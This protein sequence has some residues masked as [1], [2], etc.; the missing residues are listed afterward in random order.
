MLDVED[1]SNGKPTNEESTAAPATMPPGLLHERTRTAEVGAVHW[2]LQAY[3]DAVKS[4]D[5]EGQTALHLAASLG[6]IDICKLLVANGAD[7]NA[8]DNRNMTPFLV[9]ARGGL[10]DTCIVCT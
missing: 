6:Y 5:A 4:V 7:L 2:A 1:W 9:A 10:L 3:P 8:R